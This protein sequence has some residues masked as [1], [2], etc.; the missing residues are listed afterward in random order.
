MPIKP[1]K[2]KRLSDYDSSG[3]LGVTEMC[4]AIIFMFLGGLKNDYNYYYH[5]KYQKR[6]ILLAYLLYILFGLGVLLTLILYSS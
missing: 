2:S 1:N 3:H 6:N 5:V 4:G